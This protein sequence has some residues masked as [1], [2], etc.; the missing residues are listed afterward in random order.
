MIHK[1]LNVDNL[2]QDRWV[3]LSDDRRFVVSPRSKKA[4]VV[5]WKVL[6]YNKA[7]FVG[8]LVTATYA[9]GGITLEVSGNCARFRQG[10][11]DLWVIDTSRFAGG[12]KLKVTKENAIVRIDLSNARFPGTPVPADFSAEIAPDGAGYR[13]RLLFLWGGFEAEVGLESW[14]TGAEEAASTLLLVDEVCPLSKSEGIHLNGSPAARFYPSWMFLVAGEGAACFRG[15]QSDIT[16]DT[17]VLALLAPGMP[18]LLA[19]PPPRRS[20]VAIASSQPTDSFAFPLWPGLKD[21]WSFS[22]D[23]PVFKAIWVEAGE[24]VKG[25]DPIRRALLVTSSPSAILKF[26]PGLIPSAMTAGRLHWSWWPLSMLPLISEKAYAKQPDFWRLC[27]RRSG[28]SI[29]LSAAFSSAL[30]SRSGSS[31]P[32]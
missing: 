13:L 11:I 18:G 26:L 28:G 5:E 23:P 2:T 4:G 24:Q 10:I 19:N 25:R 16:V 17:L 30:P 1:I 12:P 6:P 32:T 14:L 22:S 20:L 29:R 31:C 27:S 3:R 15:N 8:S 21:W 9:L 7:H